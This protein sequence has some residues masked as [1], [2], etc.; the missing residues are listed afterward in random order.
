M[1]AE[2]QQ[3]DENRSVCRQLRNGRLGGETE[4]KK[5]IPH[6]DTL[7]SPSSLGVM[8]AR[9]PDYKTHTHT[10]THTDTQTHK[11]ICSEC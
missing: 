10:D 9:P 3:P 4:K 7:T 11:P 8:C 2:R 1:W 6:V 5:K